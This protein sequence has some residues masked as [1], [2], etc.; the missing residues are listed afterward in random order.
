MGMGGPVVGTRYAI[1]I[2]VKTTIGI[3]VWDGRVSTTLDFAR[4][5]LVVDTDGTHEISRSEVALRDEPV[6][7]KAKRLRDLSVH[8][9]L[10]GTVSTPLAQATAQEG[11]EVIPYVSGPVDGVLEAYMTRQLAEPCFLQP[12]CRPGA[13][14]RWR[15]G[16]GCVLGER[17]VRG[18]GQRK[19]GE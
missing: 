14:T 4:K 6:R 5:L 12:G 13:R 18:R 9:V 15:R 10:C 3:A 11:I 16:A 19:G 2:G 17:R 8:V 7:A 1:Q